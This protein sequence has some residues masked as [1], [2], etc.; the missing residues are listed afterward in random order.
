[1]DELEHESTSGFTDGANFIPCLTWV[2]RGVAK[3]Q[4]EKVFIKIS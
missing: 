4:P 2:K 1:M 3:S